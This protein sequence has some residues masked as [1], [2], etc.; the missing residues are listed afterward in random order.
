MIRKLKI[1]TIS[2]HARNGKDTV[3]GFL[4]RKLKAD[5]YKVLITHYADLV[6][7]VCEKYFGWDKLKDERGRQLL[8]YVGTDIVR[9]QQPDFWVDFIKSILTLFHSHWDYVII[10]DARFPNEIEVLKRDGLDVIHLRVDRPEFDNGL[11]DEQKH[12]PSE[13]SLDD[14]VPDYI[15][16]N[17]AGLSELSEQANTFLKEYVYEQ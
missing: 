9:Q 17:N 12:H 4:E 3:A 11:T 15:I 1:I 7:Y 8:Q 14:V 16:I 13:T 6:K 2:G 5:G 10:P